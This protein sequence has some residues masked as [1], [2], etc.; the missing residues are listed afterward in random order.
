MSQFWTLREEVQLKLGETNMHRILYVIF[1]DDLIA[2]DKCCTYLK[3]INYVVTKTWNDRETR[4][5]TGKRGETT[6]KRG[7]TTGKRGKRPGN[8]VKRPGNGVNRP[9]NGVKRPGN[10]GKLPEYIHIFTSNKYKFQNIQDYLRL[11][12]TPL[13]FLA[14]SNWIMFLIRTNVMLSYRRY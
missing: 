3:G 9:G 13:I 12:Q 1:S 7:E 14:A 8:G 6:G 11:R 5:T 4:E 10:E 2:I